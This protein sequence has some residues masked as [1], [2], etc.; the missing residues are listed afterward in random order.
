MTVSLFQQFK[1]AH[2]VFRE[3]TVIII[4]LVFFLVG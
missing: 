4:S 3:S 2:V 1:N